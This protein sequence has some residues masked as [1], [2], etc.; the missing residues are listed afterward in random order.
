MILPKPSLEDIEIKLLLEGVYQYYG[1]DF[2]NYAV[3]SL[4]RRI[5]SFMRLEG[6]DNISALQQQLLHDRACLERFLLSLTVNVTSMF[7]DPSFYLAFRNQVVPILRTYPFIRI[8]HAGCS[9]GEEVYSMAILLQE[10]NLYHRCRIYATDTNEKVLQ[11]AKSGIF[12]LKMMQEYTQLYLKAGGKRSFSEYYTAAYDHAIFRAS[13]RENI[14]FAQHN[15]ATDSSFNEFNVIFCRNVLIYFNQIL[16]KRV[17]TL[18]YNSLCSFGILG[19]G[20]QESI[21][22]TPYEQYYE[23]IAKGEKLYRRLN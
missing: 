18:F 13:L 4:K 17:H 22:F 19:L 20:K 9:S 3:S 15:L 5:H 6:V 1:H 10:E 14:I 2:R 12:S 7:R 11:N 8:W 21:R 23:E 16:Q